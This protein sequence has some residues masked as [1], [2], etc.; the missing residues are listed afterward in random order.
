LAEEKIKKMGIYDLTK[1]CYRN[2]SGGQQQRVLLARALCSASKIIIL[3]EPVT[4]LDPKMTSEFY[5]IIQ[6]LN[7]EGMAVI[8]VSHDIKAVSYAT[9]ILHIEK[10]NSFYGKKEEYLKSYKWK[11]FK[12]KGEMMDE[13]NYR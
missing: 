11:L 10:K 8:M 2:L 6:N 9:H 13:Y 12:E 7:K 3:D 1:K 5:N 4:G